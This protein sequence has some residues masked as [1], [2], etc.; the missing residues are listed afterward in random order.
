MIVNFYRNHSFIVPATVIMI[1]NYDHKT[2]LVQATGLFELWSTFLNLFSCSRL[3]RISRQSRQKP[4]HSD[5]LEGIHQISG[6]RRSAQKGKGN[7]FF[8]LF[9]GSQIRQLT[10]TPSDRIAN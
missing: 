1:A 4:R 10:S 9:M 2:F 8:K 3:L 5:G 7:Y 6:C